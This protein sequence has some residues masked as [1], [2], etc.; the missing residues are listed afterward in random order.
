MYPN[1]QANRTRH[2]QNRLG[3]LKCTFIETEVGHSC[4][5]HTHFP[6]GDDLLRCNFRFT[7]GRCLPSV[8][9]LV[10]WRDFVPCLQN[11]CKTLDV[12]LVESEKENTTRVDKKNEARACWQLRQHDTS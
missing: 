3:F 10:W 6:F 8:L 12:Y 9:V 2:K 5:C 7:Y 11:F 4:R 1:L